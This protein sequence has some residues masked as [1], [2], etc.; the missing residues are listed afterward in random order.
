MAI[1]LFVFCL[2][3]NTRHNSFP[4]TYHPDERGKALQITERSR[5]YHHPLLLL[6]ATDFAMRLG[7][8]DRTPQLATETGRWV[9]AAFA[10]ATVAALAWIA[11]LLY[12]TIAGWAAGIVLAFQI[13]LYKTAHYMKEDPALVFGLA[14]A[15]LAAHLWWREP[16]RRRLLFLGFA[17][18]LAAAGKYLG[19]V[20]LLFAIPLIV[21]RAGIEGAV[22][23]RLKT[24]ALVFAATFLLAN[25]PFFVRLNG[26]SSPFRSINH[27]VSGVAGGHHGLTRP[28]PHAIYFE[29]LKKSTPPALAVLAAI[30]AI[31]MLIV[32][33]KRSAV[34]WLTLL[35]PV[36]FVAMLSCSP[37]IAD[38]YL[39]PVNVTFTFLGALGAAELARVVDSPRSKIRHALWLLVLAGGTA[40]LVSSEIPTF[41]EAY[42]EYAADDHAMVAAWVRENLPADAL[43]AEDHRVN[44]SAS[45]ADGK[46]SDARVPQVVL[47]ADFAADLGSIGELREKGVTHV[48]VCRDSYDRFFDKAMKPGKVEKADYDRRKAF[49]TQLFAQGKLLKEWEPGKIVYL[50]PGMKLFELPPEAPKPGTP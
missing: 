20:T 17:C 49:Y 14:L 39:L 47:D 18:G 26:I 46:S 11:F 3:L 43:L 29:K 48:V 45:K 31:A 27:E 34:E 23:A 22:R 2:V 4:F 24:F 42:A 19:I 15:L 36:V 33:R 10:A 28:V 35:F 6:T 1:C 25:V 41:Q 30:Y 44:L 16:T 50:H 21:F 12:G 32:A 38:R 9:S 5:N 37:K 13:D 8:V 40:W 7:G